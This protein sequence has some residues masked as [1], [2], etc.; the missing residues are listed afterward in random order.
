[1]L[2]FLKNERSK[3]TNKNMAEPNIVPIATPVFPIMSK[4]VPTAIPEKAKR[5][6]Q[7]MT[8]MVTVKSLLDAFSISE[9]TTS[10]CFSAIHIILSDAPGKTSSY[11]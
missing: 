1:M 10:E 4:Y 8:M 2:G 7:E 11:P 6:V 5:N 3:V 9:T